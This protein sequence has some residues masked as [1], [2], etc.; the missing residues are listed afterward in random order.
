MRIIKLS[1]AAASAAVALFALVGVASANSLSVSSQTMRIAWASVEASGGF[2]S[3][4]CAFAIEGSMHTRTT[5]KTAGALIGYVTRA[6]VGP[7]EIG[8]ATVLTETLPWHVQYDS[9]TGTL[10]GI[11]SFT[12]G[13]VGAK[14]RIRE[15]VFGVTCLFTST[16]A[17]PNIVSFGLSSGRVTSAEIGGRIES[18]CGLSAEPIGTSSTV[19]AMTV[20]LI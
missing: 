8:S 4:R 2:G 19:S 13:I 18:D 12:L 10:P 11:T 15:P 6:S 17:E 9:F 1:L 5:T 7:C 20:T 14:W 16:E 3:V